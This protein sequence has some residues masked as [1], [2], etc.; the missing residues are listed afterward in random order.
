MPTLVESLKLTGNPFE[1]YVAE[2][3]P[4]I[5]EYAVKPP[6][7]GVI[8]ARARNTSSYVLF[9]D[10]GAGKSATRL[11][12]FKDLWAK[13]NSGERVPLAV[14]MTDF[15]AVVVGKTL[16]NLSE[17]ALIKEVA[18]STIE[19]LL[20]WLS[21]LE[22]EDRSVFLEAMDKEE[23]SLCY[24]L[25]RDYYLSRP[26]AKR[27]KSAREAMLLLN[28]AFVARNRLWI[29][30]RWDAVSGLFGAITDALSKRYL[31]VSGISADAAAIISKADEEFDAILLL[32]RLHDLVRVFGFSGVVT[33]VDK[34]DETQATT[35]SADQTAALIHPLLAR[36]QLLEVSGFAWIFFLWSRVKGVFE[37]S[38]YPV[39]LDKV[40]HATVAWDNEFLL[41]MLEKRVMF[42]SENKYGFAGLFSG[43][44]PVS[45]VKAELV[46]V[47]MRSPRELIR[48]MDVVV[49]EHD[50]LHG[51]DSGQA[52][53]GQDSVEMGLDKYATDVVSTMYGERLLAQIF[54]LNKLTF[55]NKDVQFTFR[56]GAQSARTR[57]QSWE[58]AGI[59]KLS[60]TR[61]AEGASGGKPANE[62]TIV[63]ARVERVMRRQL[64]AYSEAII[65]EPEFSLEDE[66]D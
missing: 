10:R 17:A 57:I 61:A 20:G 16:Q 60:G 32:H 54:R 44:V 46:R 27:S 39:R 9:G 49:R 42:Y 6:Y 36:V 3:E 47:S 24:T 56:V 34:V 19:T 37:N 52:L 30:Q 48:L 8:E 15:S 40:G 13:R 55:T 41:L 59:I 33:L 45:D 18:F 7:F 14:N 31:D 12:V 43:E 58:N 63:D 35:N 11:T 5:A 21:S 26:A 29:E 64:V 50:I 22:E 2:T 1:H 25:L 4:N 62:Y 65:E 66:T 53:I 51:E 23:V 28:Q 38:A